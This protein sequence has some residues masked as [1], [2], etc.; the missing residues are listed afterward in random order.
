[1]NSRSGFTLLELLVV[2]AILAA[3][4]GTAAI[5]LKDTDARASAA[6]HVAMMDEL[7]KGIQTY[8]VLKRNELPT[9]FD[10]LLTVSGSNPGFLGFDP[11]SDAAIAT[12]PS[13]VQT[14]MKDGGITAL[15]YIDPAAEPEGIVAGVAD[16]AHIQT[17]I[18]SRA[19]NVVAGNVFLP[20]AANGCGTALQLDGTARSGVFW[21]EGSLR[22]T[23][24]EDAADKRHVYLLTGIGPSS[25]LF[26]TNSLGGMTTVPVYR[27]V[28]PDEYNRFIAVW[29]V[30]YVTDSGDDPL[31]S[32]ASFVVGDQ[33][34][35]VT[36]LDGALDTKEEELGEW[37][38]TRNTI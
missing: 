21:T 15:M 25:T 18:N 28:K 33:I 12:I 23:G 38:G 26:D 19:N 37:D 29:N 24:Q 3:V 22:L 16:C 13:G 1:M 30:G 9:R 4:A 11:E 8:R 31:P 5:A 2:V 27:H 7:N 34:D 10:S 20:E 17:L 14:I 32:A 36:I 35:L 6:A